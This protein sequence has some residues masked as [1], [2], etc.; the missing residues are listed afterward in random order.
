MTS[1]SPQSYKEQFDNYRPSK[2]ALFWSCVACVIVTIVIG[3]GWGGWVTGG[4]AEEMVDDAAEQS[5]AQLA[6]AI[7]VDRFM[8]GNETR[9]QL[10]ELKDLSSYQRG[11]FIEDG[12]WAVMPGS[13]QASD[14]AAE[15]CADQLAERELPPA[16]EASG[17]NEGATVAQ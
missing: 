12:T 1:E 4:T 16:Q 2:T 13:E 14:E 7:C 3:F 10:V 5:R 17:L 6:A 8:A 11:E 15:L 9:A